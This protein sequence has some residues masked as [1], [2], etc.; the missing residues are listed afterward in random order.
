MKTN[1]LLMVCISGCK[2]PNGLADGPPTVQHC[3]TIYVLHP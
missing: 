2:V 1:L 3:L